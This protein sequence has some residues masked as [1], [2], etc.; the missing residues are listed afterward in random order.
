MGVRPSDPL[1]SYQFQ[2][3][4]SGSYTA[5]GYFTEV[6]GV[7]AEHEVTEHKIVDHETGKE[8]VQQIPGRIKW[9]EITF[10]KGLTTNTN[11][12]EWHEHV[13]NGDTET[14]R[15]EVTLT[16]YDRNYNPA[17]NWV[18]INA[19]PSKVSGPE[20]KADSSDFTVEELTMV[21][22]GLYRADYG[23]EDSGIPIRSNDIA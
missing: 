8:L 12:W 18:F 1:L 4:V 13:V 3:E 16:M 9:N 20:M 10:K 2:I 6:S 14:S 5:T 19:W 7:G 11:F 23:G 21:H 22:E 17:V 15:C